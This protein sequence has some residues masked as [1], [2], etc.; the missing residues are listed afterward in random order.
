MMAVSFIAAA[1]RGFVPMRLRRRIPPILPRLSRLAAF[2][3]FSAFLLAAFLWL[4]TPFGPALA[5][6]PRLS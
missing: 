6:L 2:L 3:R 4:P 5:G 1:G